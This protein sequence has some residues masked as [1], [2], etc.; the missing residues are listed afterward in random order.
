[1][2]YLLILFFIFILAFLDV[3]D[4]AVFPKYK[5]TLLIFCFMLMFIIAGFRYQ[6]GYDF[7]S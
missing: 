4:D 1:M 7:N 2:I 3:S 5:N 6:V